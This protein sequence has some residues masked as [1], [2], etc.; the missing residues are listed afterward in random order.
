MMVRK[1][2]RVVLQGL[3]AS[4]GQALGPAFLLV[5][6]EVDVPVHRVPPEGVAGEIRLFRRA[7]REA[8]REILVLRER[9][10]LVPEDPGDQILASHLMIL[11]DRELAKEIVAAIKAEQSN[12]AAIVRRAFAAKAH[13][14]ET[15]ASEVFRA[16]AADVRDVQQR[17]LA[18][19]LGRTGGLMGEAPAG[20]IVVAREI[21]PSETLALTPGGVAGLVTEQG[22][23]MSHVTI[24]A[25]SRGV[26]AVI[27]VD[28]ALAT[29][30][31][32]EPLLLDGDRG[33]V[34]CSPNDEDVRRHEETRAREKRIAHRVAR[35]EGRPGATRDGRRVP[36]A[37]NIERPE[38]AEAAR[39]AGAEGIGLFRTEFLFL[40]GS[41]LPGEAAQTSAYEAVSRAFPESAVTIRTLDVGGDKV[42]GLIA[43]PH[44]ENPFLGLRGIRFCLEHP[45]MFLAQVRALLRASA[46]GNVRILLPMVSAAGELRE[47]RRLI[48]QTAE[49]LRDEGHAVAK[50]SVGL[51]IEVPSAVWMSDALAREADF[52]SIG[53]NDLIQYCL[54]VDRGNAQ[55]AHL[56]DGLDPAVLRALDQTVR[57][58][59]G[60]GIRVG[61]CGEMSG[62]LPGLLLLVGLGIDELSVAPFL[63]AR[64][65]AVL[66][67]VD[68]ADLERLARRCLAAAAVEEVRR[69]VVAGLRQYPQFHFEEHDGLT[70]LW[71]PE[72]P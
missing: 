60:A 40:A 8:R 18:R 47:A 11:Q 57:G 29:V 59:H 15:L 65:K 36:I 66:A 2:K 17:L 28:A 27:G 35:V 25:R 38:D 24:L 53:S 55:I 56:Y 63:V 69:L 10:G 41:G 20:S 67:G 33:L 68:A 64:T 4:P 42:G 21:T 30:T 1:D 34:V 7:V 54:A 6:R 50:P 31:A 37:A 23:L 70:C 49:T 32:G 44:E 62:E 48:E 72:T 45:E 43:L 46:R 9:L 3:G 51:M 13:Y 14:L 12:A 71:D 5:S 39:R 58:A 16:R 19:L 26:P 22:T 52:F 61:S